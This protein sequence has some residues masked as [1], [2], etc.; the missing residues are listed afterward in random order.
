MHEYSVARDIV[1][2]AVREA[3]RQS[4]TGVAAIYI[5]LG[6]EASIDPEALA[7]GIEVTAQGT[8]AGH[9]GIRVRRVP[10]CSVV[11]ESLELGEL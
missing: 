1:D 4:A 8:V 6:T 9:A 10:G 2:R 11:L 3:A 5:A 7:L